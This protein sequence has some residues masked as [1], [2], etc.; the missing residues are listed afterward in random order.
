MKQYL[1]LLQRILSEGIVSEDRT[2]TGT[3]RIFGAQL[4]FNLQEGFPLVTTK[5]INY[6]ASIH[7]LIWMLKGTPFIDYLHENNVHIWDNWATDIYADAPDAP[8]SAKNWLGPVYGCQ[9]RRWYDHEEESTID[10]LQQV[11]NEI[12]DN[13]YSRRL[14]VSA[15][16]VTY[17]KDMNLQPCHILFQ[18]HADPVNK[19]LSLS[20]YQRSADV[21]LG[22]PFDISLYALLLSMV[23]QLTG[24]KAKDMIIS[25][26][27]AHLYLNHLEQAKLQL[28]NRPYK[29]PILKLNPDIKCIDDFKFE[30]IEI[31]NYSC[32]PA[33]K[34]DISV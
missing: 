13:P 3:K 34:A 27:D 30:D 33:I 14:V 8:D 1:D 5:K 20:M 19:E 25:I 24:Y 29:L 16:N 9:W 6:R 31:I 7:E 17:L 2:G 4:R 11:I 26:G 28:E 10:Q 18:F 15:W 12:K 23:A 22:L 32:Y 21:F